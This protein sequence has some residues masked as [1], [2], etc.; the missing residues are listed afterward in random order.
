MLSLT[1]GQ[2]GLQGLSKPVLNEGNKFPKGLLFLKPTAATK[3]DTILLPY[4]LRSKPL[5]HLEI[6]WKKYNLRCLIN[7]V[8]VTVILLP[9]ICLTYLLVDLLNQHG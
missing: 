8:L 4:S 6:S 7:E 2:R 5:Q 9:T 1:V 3:S